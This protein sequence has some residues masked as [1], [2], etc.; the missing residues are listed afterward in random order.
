M[1]IL[2]WCVAVLVALMPLGVLA[3]VTVT[4]EHHD[5]VVQGTTAGALM[6]SLNTHPVVGD[7]GRAYAST[8]VEFGLGLRAVE[9]GGMCSAKVDV[10]LQMTVTLPRAASRGRMSGR[11]GRAWDAFVAFARTHE[12]HHQA[13]YIDCARR[14]VAAAERVTEKQCAPLGP[15]IDRLF[16]QMQA[17]CEIAQ[18]DF[19]RQ[20][21]PIAGHMDLFMMGQ[22]DLLN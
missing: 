21:R 16:K 4:V 1:S 13:S 20:Q 22:L 19:D 17:D 2:R 8:H 18:A 14:F 10:D 12:A 9:R 5:N 11:V 15:A 7:S 3:G 6:V